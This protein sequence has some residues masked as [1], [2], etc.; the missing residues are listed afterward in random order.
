MF[1]QQKPHQSLYYAVHV[2]AVGCGTNK[3]ATVYST[4]F[5]MQENINNFLNIPMSTESIL[6]ESLTKPTF[7]ILLST[8]PCKPNHLNSQVTSL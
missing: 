7:W 5:Y 4:Q 2:D 8:V 6:S 1:T 3:E